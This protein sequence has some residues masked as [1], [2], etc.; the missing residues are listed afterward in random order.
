MRAQH[1]CIWIMLPNETAGLPWGLA[2]TNS[3]R[4]MK[5]NTYIHGGSAG[6]GSESRSRTAT[7]APFKSST[8]YPASGMS[9]P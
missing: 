2:R 9:L 3:A 6:K 5:N 4:H 8:F 7:P 1:L